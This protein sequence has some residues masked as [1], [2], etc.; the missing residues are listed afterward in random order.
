MHFTVYTFCEM[1]SSPSDPLG[2]YILFDL[3]M[4]TLSSRKTTYLF[5]YI[6]TKYYMYLPYLIQQYR[7]QEVSAS[8]YRYICSVSRSLTSNR[9]TVL[10]VA[11]STTSHDDNSYYV[12]DLENPDSSSSSSSSRGGGLTPRYSLRR[13]T[14]IK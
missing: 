5:L 9:E 7:T 14:T 4:M 13:R 12:N 2:A 11:H 3:A 8:T 10:S 6:P 1:S